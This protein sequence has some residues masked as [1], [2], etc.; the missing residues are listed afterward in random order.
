MTLTWG[1]PMGLPET[2]QSSSTIPQHHGQHP[3]SSPLPH[4]KRSEPTVCGIQLLATTLGSCLL[5]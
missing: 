2:V 4:P 1:G 5:M 3:H